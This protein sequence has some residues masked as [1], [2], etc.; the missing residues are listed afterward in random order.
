[1]NATIVVVWG[2]GK[3]LD[4]PDNIHL[5]LYKCPEMATNCGRCMDLKYTF[6][7]GWC[8][9]WHLLFTLSRIAISKSTRYYF[10]FSSIQLLISQWF[11]STDK[12]SFYRKPSVVSYQSTACTSAINTNTP[13]TKSQGANQF[14]ADQVPLLITTAIVN[15]TR[16]I[17]TTTGIYWNL[18]LSISVLKNCM[19]G[20]YKAE[21]FAHSAYMKNFALLSLCAFVR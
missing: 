18:N 15:K 10:G 2:G 6:K 5:E 9:V 14:A 4:N 1:M 17:K 16:P 20:F 11:R 3:P 8:K 13:T 21:S 19:V 7:C 12:H